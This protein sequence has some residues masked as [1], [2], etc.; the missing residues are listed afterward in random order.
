[1][2]ECIEANVQHDLRREQSMSTL[3]ETVH[4]LKLAAPALAA[5]SAADR[6]RALAAMAQA[7]ADNRD[8]IY[9]ANAADMEAAEAAGL[10]SSLVK[11][12]KFD[13]SKL[14][15]CTEGL[16]QL[17][18]L[19]DPIGKV[20]L[21]RELDSGLELKRVTTPIGVIG[22]IF[23]AR[24]D[25]LVQISGLCMKSGNC[26]I[27]K[28]GKEAENTNGVLFEVL[29][30]AAA[31]VDAIPENVM[32]RVSSHS[33]ID[34]ILKLDGDVDLIIPRGSNAFVRHIM[35]NTKIPVMGHA[36]GICHIYI[37]AAADLE[38][39]KTIAVDAKIQYP[40]ACNAVETLL[41]NESIAAQF[42][43]ELVSALHDAGVKVRGDKK[44]ADYA[45]ID[46]TF[47]D[48]SEYRREY[49]ELTLAVAV[50]KDV[51]EACAHINRYGSHH[52]DSIITADDAAAQYFFSMVDSAGVYRNCSTRFSDG[53]RYGFGAEVGIST[54]K[55]HAR[56]P[57]G[58]EG[59][60]SYK[61][62]LEG[63]GQRVREYAEGTKSFDFRDRQP[64]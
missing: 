64:V 1:M 40:A 55:L 6:N 61:Y 41:I 56:G 50:V 32:I 13:D 63:S 60:T 38:M 34:E 19:P 29:R 58:L 31:G 44:A 48:S 28:G 4:E 54:S 9:A 42:L 17:A 62:I 24:P 11:R 36:D 25:A 8:R 49:G 20:T 47:E 45:A 52:T 46:E 26:A 22:V 23:E 33:E 2:R 18:E 59:L 39:A 15:A 14:M 3:R 57:V 37:D 51:S 27:L 43:P 7:L 12:L 35:D 16:K 10:K 21:D 30:E 5:V 53:F